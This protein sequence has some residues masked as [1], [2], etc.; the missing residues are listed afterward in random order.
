[1]AK[2]R[3]RRFRLIASRADMDAVL[4]EIVRLSCVEVTQPE[5]LPD[6][7]ALSPHVTPES[8]D[9]GRLGASSGD[10]ELLGTEYTL[11]L[12]GWISARGISGLTSRLSD[13]V[14]AWEIGEP[15]GDDDASAPVMLFMPRLFSKYR[16]KGRR[17]F[18]PLTEAQKQESLDAT[19]GRGSEAR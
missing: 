10:L 8:Y 4:S 19:P 17:L 11:V 9:S 7:P 1:M 6:D 16:A 12:T 15:P 5:E 2:P 14:C 3:V 18:A 13:Y